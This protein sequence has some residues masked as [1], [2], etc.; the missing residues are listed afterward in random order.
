MKARRP[1]IR[2]GY[3][4]AICFLDHVEDAS[5][6]EQFVV[7]GRVAEVARKHICVDCWAYLKLTEPYDLNVKRFT[8][9]RSTIQSWDRL[10]VKDDKPASKAVSE[11]SVSTH[12]QS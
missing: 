10:H 12:E 7:Y 3:V 8:I 11:T 2:V 6:P 1:P 9:L 5:E 4:V